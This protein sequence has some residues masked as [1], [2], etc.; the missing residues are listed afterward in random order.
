V[1]EPRGIFISYRREDAAGHARALY[2]QLATR[3]G[4]ERVFMDVDAIG[5]GVNV[6]ERIESAIG[7]SGV[8]LALIGKDWLTAAGAGGKRRLDD[9]EDFVRREIA[10]ALKREIK[11]IPVLVQGAKMP[12]RSE[13]PP[14]LADLSEPSALELSDVYWKPAVERLSA[15]LAPLLGEAPLPPEPEPPERRPRVAVAVGLVGLALLVAGLVLFLLGDV[16]FQPNF[17]SLPVEPVLFTAPAPIGVLLGAVVAILISTRAKAASWLG[18][19]LS[20]GFG[21]E[22]AAKGL[23]LLG[24]DSGRVRGGGLLWFAGGCAVVAAAALAARSAREP[25]SAQREPSRGALVPIVVAVGAAALV[26]ATFIPFNVSSGENRLVAEQGW[27]AVDPLGT[28]LAALS[29]LAV[30]AGRRRAA[31]GL[32]VALGLGSTLL[33][34]RYVGIP[35]AQWATEGEDVASPRAGGVV[36]LAGSLIILAVGCRLA[37]S[38]PA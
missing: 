20:L 2:E 22:A 25:P 15:A 4:E 19:G 7:T 3:F 27:S 21:I 11:V 1:T 37:S 38:R 18:I 8:L 12:S 6:T 33:W 23:S 29:A 35:V 14:A 24:D 28:A 17:P 13:L 5:L 16:Y 36:G 34:I 31:G 32:L 10:G 9:P 30:S 26:V